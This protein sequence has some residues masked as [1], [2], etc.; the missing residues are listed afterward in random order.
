VITLLLVEEFLDCA[1]VIAVVV[2]AIYW[3]RSSHLSRRA[4]HES[5]TIRAM[6]NARAATTAAIAATM[7]ALA[8]LCRLGE[9]VNQTVS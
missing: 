7:Q 8:V 6:L 9:I 3:W 4:V 5:E 2:S 1:A